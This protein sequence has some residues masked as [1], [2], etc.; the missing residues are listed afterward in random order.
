VRPTGETG[1]SASTSPPCSALSRA[2]L[3][4]G[5]GLHDPGVDPIT[6]FDGAHVRTTKRDTNSCDLVLDVAAVLNRPLVTIA[7][8]PRPSPDRRLSV[9]IGSACQSR[10]VPRHGPG[11]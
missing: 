11:R 7:D 4:T 3:T 9:S 6:Q 2:L 10:R 5:P 1:A 8:L